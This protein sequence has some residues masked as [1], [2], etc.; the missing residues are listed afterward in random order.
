MADMCWCGKALM[1]LPCGDAEPGTD[2][3]RYL[4]CPTHGEDCVWRPCELRHDERTTRFGR[5]KAD[6]NLGIGDEQGLGPSICAECPVPDDR[7]DAK[8]WR[9]Y[10][11]ALVAA[12]RAGTE[13]CRA[14]QMIDTPD[15][16]DCAAKEECE[17]ATAL[18]LLDR[19]GEEA[20][21][22]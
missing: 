17:M 12:V 10:G 14:M 22:D 11:P 20:R 2:V 8:K 7:R 1:L 3:E 18:A 6:C 4:G 15:C 9:D 19:A 16:E 13:T 5:V 21:D